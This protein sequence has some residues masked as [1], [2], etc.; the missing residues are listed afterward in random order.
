MQESSN[1]A[2]SHKNQS[3][4]IRQV[5]QMM[6]EKQRTYSKCLIDFFNNKIQYFKEL[7][8]NKQINL[9]EAIVL[10]SSLITY[11]KKDKIYSYGQEPDGFYMIVE[12][13]VSVQSPNLNF[14]QVQ[15]E[16]L[17]F[18]ETIQLSNGSHFGD[19]EIN[20]QKLRV[21][22]IICLS[23]VLVVLFLD[24]KQF[25]SILQLIKNQYVFREGEKSD[26]IYLI[27]SGDFCV[28]KDKIVQ[29]PHNSSVLVCKT[30]QL[31]R[32]KAGQMFGEED[33]FE[34]QNRSYDVQCLSQQGTLW[35]IS[36]EVYKNSLLQ[37]GDI[38]RY[39]YQTVGQKLI[40][41][42]GKL[43]D[44]M[45]KYVSQC[46]QIQTYKTPEKKEQILS[47]RKIKTEESNH[48]KAN[49]PINNLQEK[50][51]NIK[52]KNLFE[53]NIEDTVKKIINSKNL[54][55]STTKITKRPS[56]DLSLLKKNKNK[57]SPPQISGLNNYNYSDG[58][59]FQKRFSFG[60]QEGDQGIFA[61]EEEEIIEKNLKY[62]LNK[63][64]QILNNSGQ[65]KT[66][67]C[68][69]KSES[70]NKKYNKQKAILS[71][72][73]FNDLNSRMSLFQTKPEDETAQNNKNEIVSLAN[74]Q[75]DSDEEDNNEQINQI[76]YLDNTLQNE[77]NTEQFKIQILDKLGNENKNFSKVK[78]NT[79]RDT[80]IQNQKY[81]ANT[82]DKM[83]NLGNENN[84]LIQ[85]NQN[86]QQD[87]QTHKEKI[88]L[89]RKSK[90][91]TEGNQTDKNQKNEEYKNI[92]EEIAKQL[93]L[94]TATVQEESNKYQLPYIAPLKFYNLIQN[95]RAKKLVQKSANTSYQNSSRNSQERNFVNSLHQSPERSKLNKLSDYSQIRSQER[96]CKRKE[97]EQQ[98]KMY[99]SIYNNDKLKKII[100]HNY[101]SN[102]QQGQYNEKQNNQ[103]GNFH[104]LVDS[105]QNQ[106]DNNQKQQMVY[107]NNIYNRIKGT[108]NQEIQSMLT[109]TTDFYKMQTNRS[110]TVQN[111][112]RTNNH[113]SINNTNYSKKNQ[114]TNNSPHFQ[115][116]A[117]DQTINAQI[118]LES[119]CQKNIQKKL[120][121]ITGKL[122]Q[123]QTKVLYIKHPNSFYIH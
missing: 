6:Q 57:Q 71:I 2:G 41:Y 52:A 69:L 112:E 60:S 63:A 53:N 4:D 42:E 73:T 88:Q 9:I 55:F 22:Q 91:K 110:T 96:A 34:Q 78:Q 84:H 75:S 72:T 119:V 98:T 90:Q 50:K 20:Q 46:S 48:F 36:S 32:L 30:F 59:S 77:L 81:Q 76:D 25:V 109:K 3:L 33:T 43:R 56:P 97:D 79:K 51:I 107:L 19:Y 54:E 62:Q 85:N 111:T 27:I 68:N 7:K 26:G 47:D 61:T 24:K 94:E 49:L 37:N 12:G 18:Q 13:K 106:F 70:S 80:L 117:F 115:I 39:L 100:L 1:I 14:A 45:E 64:F 17:P 105:Q 23:K 28:C 95:D 8:D 38:I 92:I 87:R 102:T 35:I 123:T 67:K 82:E 103:K 108:S 16:S 114:S 122:N 93:K 99:D 10:Q 5:Q 66:H 89:N 104:D 121:K 15:D 120:Q 29:S 116:S 86:V 101:I 74:I 83:L 113:L 40:Y 118:N 65:R 31:L 58:K 21:H 11:Q 44:L